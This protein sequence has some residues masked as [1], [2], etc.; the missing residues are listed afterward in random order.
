[1][2]L[3]TIQTVPDPALSLWQSSAMAVAQT[4][5]GVAA[6]GAGRSNPL[7]HPL[8]EA[9]AQHALAARRGL[10][11]A[12]PADATTAPDPAFLSHLHFSLANARLANDADQVSVLEA[13]VR[14][15]STGDTGWDS[16]W[17]TCEYTYLFYRNQFGKVRKYN[18]YQ[19]MNFSVI[20]YQLPADAV[21]VVLGD[22][23]TGQDD[24]TQLL[25][26]I[27]AQHKPTAIIHLG[28]IYYSGTPAGLP[29]APWYPGECQ[30]NFLNV[31]TS[32]FEGAGNRVPVFALPGN[33]EYYS[34]GA[35]YYNEVLPNV[36]SGI[37]DAE[38]PASYF[39][40]RT[41]D[42]LWQF[43]G[44]DTGYNDADP[45]YE[46][47]PAATAP[48]LQDDEAKWHQDKLTNFTGTTIL[49]SHHQLFSANARLN[50]QG[51]KNPPNIN[52]G[53][54]A[55]FKDYFASVAA[56]LWGHEH[57]LALYK[58]DLLGLAK[59]RLIGCSSY[60][61]T[62]DE[63]PYKQIYDDTPFLNPGSYQLDSDSGYY[64]HGYA[65][66]DFQ[67]AAP[68]DAIT[69]SY[70]QYPSWGLDNRPSNPSVQLIYSESLSKPQAAQEPAG[71]A[72]TGT[73]PECR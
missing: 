68:S 63:N 40:L 42:G 33:H 39:C 37:A 48:Q 25:S 18:S 71:H 5:D 64:N 28:D 58:A 43:L 69:I 30:N 34:F 46:I 66:I 9:T 22:W 53:L 73:S 20:G 31:L 60:E 15:Y 19:Q 44:M 50:G 4:E 54:Q 62:T 8:V 27:M 45:G 2:M 21:V 36:N 41:E 23:G 38:Q 13:T 10:V 26:A 65:V 1:M 47:N 3:R 70:F 12:E 56:W 29:K 59:G 14:K 16:G 55:Q 24:A 11:I 51:T 35:G 72:G 17:T 57:N 49:L 7:S 67:R 32:V 52:V 6:S 61:E